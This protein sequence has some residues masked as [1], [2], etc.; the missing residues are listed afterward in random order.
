M[1]TEDGLC[2]KEIPRR[3]AMGKAAMEG[4]TTI[5]KGRGITLVTKVKLVKAL[6][7][8]IV[9][10]GAENWTMRKAKRNKNDA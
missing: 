1:I 10:Y 4:L 5:W 7:F 8:P 9:L 6:I 3:I 2:D